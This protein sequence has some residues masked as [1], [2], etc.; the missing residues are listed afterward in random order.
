MNC[1]LGHTDKMTVVEQ[2]YQGGDHGIKFNE[3]RFTAKTPHYYAHMYREAICVF[4]HQTNNNRKE[5]VLNWIK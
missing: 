3:M 2:V 1:R 5:K 4:K